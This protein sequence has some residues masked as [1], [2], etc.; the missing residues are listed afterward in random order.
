MPS[1]LM[2]HLRYPE[3]Q[4]KVQRDLLSRFHVTTPN[5]FFSGQ[6]FW[7]VP[8]DP[9]NTALD[10][11]PYYIVAKLPGQESAR[12]QLTAAVSPRNRGNLAALLSASYV[13]GQPRFEVLELP[14]DTAIPGPNQVHGNMTSIPEARTDLTQFNSQ[15]SKVIYGNLLSLP[16]SDGMLYIEPL[17]L[18][19][20]NENAYPFLRKVLVAYGGKYVAYADNLAA[21]LQSLVQQATGQAP[22]PAAG[23][24]S[25]T[26]GQPSG[27]LAE[28]VAAMDKAI[29]DLKAAQQT[30]DFEGYG[31]A[32]KSLQDAIK[33]YEDAK[34]AAP[35]GVPTPGASATPSPG[36]PAPSPS[37]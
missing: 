34:A 6:D 24:P 21:G 11:P 25:N 36:A 23:P 30:G 37:G 3:D 14:P 13:N 18:R 26:G 5:G 19:S 32:L 35:S 17:Y 28:A 20:T 29:A 10:Q 31:K 12:F 1:E 22:P 4:F 16:V 9:G 15:N 8:K 33:R 27:A 2:D 7:Q